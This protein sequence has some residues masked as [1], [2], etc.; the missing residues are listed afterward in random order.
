MKINSISAQPAW[1]LAAKISALGV[2]LLLIT[3]GLIWLLL[4]TLSFFVKEIIP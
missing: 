3:Y 4:T 1:K 2:C